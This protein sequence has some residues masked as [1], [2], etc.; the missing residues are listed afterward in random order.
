MKGFLKAFITDT[1]GFEFDATR[2]NKPDRHGLTLLYLNGDEWYLKD[3]Y[4]VE[5]MRELIELLDGKEIRIRVVSR[6]IAQNTT[7]LICVPD[8]QPH[9]SGENEDY[10]T[11]L[12][13]KRYEYPHHITECWNAES[14]PVEAAKEA[15][16]YVS[17]CKSD[18]RHR[19]GA[20]PGPGGAGAVSAA[21]R[22]RH[23]C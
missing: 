16:K 9:F 6:V 1:K 7:H 10:W 12:L 13:E 23:R 2:V 19:P 3:E 11:S 17:A 15:K 14:S 20:P 8:F 22:P 4:D 18:F 5:E 21:R